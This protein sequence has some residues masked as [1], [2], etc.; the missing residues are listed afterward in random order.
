[1]SASAGYA[2]SALEHHRGPGADSREAR[3]AAALIRRRLPC[4]RLA[5]PLS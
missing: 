4:P 2:V 1:M 5:D 3:Q